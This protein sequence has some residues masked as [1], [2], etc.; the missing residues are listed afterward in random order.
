MPGRS[1]WATAASHHALIFGPT[2]QYESISKTWIETS[3]LDG[4]DNV[5]REF[6]IRQGDQIFYA[7]TYK[8]HCLRNVYRGGAPAPQLA[9]IVRHS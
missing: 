5:K 3:D 7:G 9:E 6:F 2:H 8:C 4:L 1:L